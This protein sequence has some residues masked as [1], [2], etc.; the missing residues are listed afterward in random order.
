MPGVER[1]SRP[2]RG[3]GGAAAT[4]RALDARV[5]KVLKAGPWLGVD[6]DVLGELVDRKQRLRR[7]FTTSLSQANAFMETS[8]RAGRTVAA[9]LNVLLEGK[10]KCGGVRE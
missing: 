9:S 2:A 6:S 8:A 7:L 4:A 10:S 1:F 5:E 3:P